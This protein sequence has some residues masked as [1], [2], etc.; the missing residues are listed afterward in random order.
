MFLLFKLMLVI[1][2]QLDCSV[3]VSVSMPMFISMPDFV[4]AS[5]PNHLKPFCKFSCT[6]KILYPTS[7]GATVCTWVQLKNHTVHTKSLD[8]PSHSKS[9]LY[10]HDYEYCSFTLKASKL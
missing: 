6:I 8:T 9:C 3:L 10:F 1:F 2:S 4:N 5:C 7:S